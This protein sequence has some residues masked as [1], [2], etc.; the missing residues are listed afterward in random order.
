MLLSDFEGTDSLLQRPGTDSVGP[1]HPK[2]VHVP[3]L[4]SDS[5]D[6]AVVAESHTIEDDLKG[7]TWGDANMVGSHHRLHA[8]VLVRGGELYHTLALQRV[9]QGAKATTRVSVTTPV[10]EPCTTACLPTILALVFHLHVAHGLHAHVVVHLA[11]VGDLH[12]L[13]R[14]RPPPVPATTG[15]PIATPTAVAWSVALVEASLAAVADLR[16]VRRNSAHVPPIVRQVHASALG[17]VVLTVF[18]TGV[19][20]AAP[21]ACART[22][23]LA[24]AVLSGVHQS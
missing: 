10:A 14:V 23:A 7:L 11:K 19:V 15:V 1:G 18:A 5:T 8:H 20:V 16:L 3:S 12:A 21:A 2:L 17:G 13:G 24:A 6:L 22:H 9:R 4:P